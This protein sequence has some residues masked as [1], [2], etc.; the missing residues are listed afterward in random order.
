MTTHRIFSLAA[1][2]VWALGC[3]SVLGIHEKEKFGPFLDAG[4]PMN[5]DAD[6]TVPGDGGSFVLSIVKP[7]PRANGTTPPVHVV[8]G[9]SASIDVAVERS[10]FEGTVTVLVSGL[11]RGVTA[12][13]LVLLPSQNTGSL[14]IR[15]TDFAELGPASLSI[16]GVHQDFVPSPLD[17]PLIV[18]DAPGTPDKTF[19]DGGK[20]VLPVGLGGVGPGGIQLLDNGSIVLCGHAKTDA[21]PSALVISRILSSGALDPTFTMGAGFALGNS[22]GSTADSCS[23]VFLRPNG[24]IVFTGVATPQADQPRAMLTGR[25]RPDGFP[26]QNFGPGGF[27]TTPL[28]GMG[29]EGYSVVGPTLGDT[30]VVGGWG[31]M[32]P[33][34]LRF[35]KNGMLDTAFGTENVQELSVSGGVRWVTQQPNGSFLTAIDSSTFLVARFSGNGALD[36]TFGDNGTAA[37]PVGPSSSAAVVLAPSDDAV[38]AVGTQTVGAGTKDIAWARLTSAGQVDSAFATA[39]V[40]TVHFPGASI[41]S[42]AAEHDGA[43]MIAGQTPTDAGPAFTV[44]RVSSDG[45]LDTTFGTAGRSVL[46]VGMAQAVAVEDELGRI[47]V[48]G[49][50]GG[51]TEGSL[52]VYRLWP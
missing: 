45:T 50:S 34:L 43:I 37:V 48:A 40:G 12:D 14:T 1:L 19:G 49:F 31:R 11:A 28:D 10:G 15:A 24:G 29:S 23:A 13:A 36:R 3:S 17:V 4:V 30:F 26:D 35:N 9:S 42:S 5:G 39:G 33:A 2:A 41:V 21:A 20:V 46:G 16:L 7:P 25:Y 18:Q 6:A 22:P 32:H 52:V 38:F 51:S 27:G 47:L 44:L 8:R